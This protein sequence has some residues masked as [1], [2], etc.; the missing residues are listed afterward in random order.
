[1]SGPAPAGPALR[2]RETSRTGLPDRRAGSEEACGAVDGVREPLAEPSTSWPGETVTQVESEAETKAVRGGHVCAGVRREC[3]LE[4]PCLTGAKH[5]G[6]QAPVP[7]G[8]VLH[9]E[10]KL[11]A[12]AD[13]GEGDKGSERKV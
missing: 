12:E 5:S 3:P 1:M 6:D 8:S 7:E 9:S 11:V 10:L 13:T 4:S 2:P